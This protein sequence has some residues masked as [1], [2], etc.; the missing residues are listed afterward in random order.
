MKSI[1]FSGPMWAA[2]C[3]VLI[4]CMGIIDYL[5]GF[6]IGFSLFYLIPISLVAWYSGRQAGIAASV[7][8]AIVWL[9]SDIAAGQRYSHPAIYI[10]NTLIRLGFFIAFT[11]LLA[12][13]R[14]TLEQERE[15]ART[16]FLT[17]VL[18]SRSFYDI[19]QMEI[20]RLQRY[21]RPFSI[22]Y[23]D[24]DNF[25]TVNDQFGHSIGDEV[26]RTVASHAQKNLR[27]TD[28]VARL[29]GDE[30]AL[31]LPESTPELARIAVTKLQNCLLQVMQANRWPVTFS[32]GVVSCTATPQSADEL[33]K[34]AD[35]LMY[36]AKHGGKN[37]VHYDVFTG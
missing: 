19:L 10:W 27:R 31:L 18:N 29:G 26:L 8:S 14:K 16:D 35:T 5:T 13:L 4:L 17:G 15:M 11:L 22:A 9:V 1:Q 12:T 20:D 7:F 36:T 3:F 30:F 24:L 6:E 2:I 23:I 37:T 21:N 33:I 32:L 25:K 34:L 28:V